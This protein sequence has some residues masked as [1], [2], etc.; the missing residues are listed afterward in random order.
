[1][2]LMIPKKMKVK[3]MSKVDTQEKK[4]SYNIERGKHIMGSNNYIYKFRTS[5]YLEEIDDLSG[6]NVGKSGRDYIREQIRNTAKQ[7]PK[8]QGVEFYHNPHNVDILIQC[9][10]NI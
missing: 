4:L 9:P 1:M 2:T 8:I 3:I 10:H 5:Q 7:I 6:H